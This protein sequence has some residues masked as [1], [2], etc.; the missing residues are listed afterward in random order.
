MKAKCYCGTD[1]Y[2]KCEKVFD[3]NHKSW[4]CL[5]SDN[6]GNIS[7]WI[8]FFMLLSHVL[9]PVL[10]A[11]VF[12][13]YRNN[14]DRNYV[15][16]L[17][18]HPRLYCFLIVLFSPIILVSALFNLPFIWGWLCVGCL[19]EGRGKRNKNIWLGVRLFFYLPAVLLTF[20]G[21]LLVL[22]LVIAFAPLYGLG[23]LGYLLFNEK[24]KK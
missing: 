1:F 17:N 16:E 3:D 14:W 20:L 11:I 21:L 22:G 2:M 15:S 7:Y 24:G 5:A 18:E 9:V 8:I 6:Q 23:L 4:V 19:F 13:W 10:P 12:F